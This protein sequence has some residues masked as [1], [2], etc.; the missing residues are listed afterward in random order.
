MQVV[1]L[2]DDPQKHHWGILEV[3]QGR[4]GSQYR[5]FCQAWHSCGQLELNPTEKLGDAVESTV[6]SHSSQ[7]AKDLGIYLPTPA[8]HWLF[9]VIGCPLHFWPSI[10]VIALGPITRENPQVKWHRC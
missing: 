10:G 9:S 5:V 8:R 1:Y 7:G 4:K 3:K 6:F 2:G